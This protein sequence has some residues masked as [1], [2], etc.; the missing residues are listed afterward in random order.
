MTDVE[1]W[2]NRVELKMSMKTLWLDTS[3]MNSTLRRFFD[4]LPWFLKPQI[5]GLAF[6][7]GLFLLVTVIGLGYLTRSD[8]I[9]SP[10]TTAIL[11]IISAPTATLPVP[12]PSLDLTPASEGEPGLESAGEGIVLDGYVQIT[13]TGGT[14]LRFR[15]TPSLA[16]QV[17]F[18]A[19][20]AEIFI[21][22][23]GPMDADGYQ[24]WYLVGPF[25]ETRNGWAVSDFLA[26]TQNPN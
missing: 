22:K 20:E 6:V 13:G 19:S 16:G 7:T 24:W 8:P 10:K 4:Q 18:V 3:K 12:T 26:L 15:L 23:D 21:V 14:G 9:K 2:E 5:I 11:N 25:D 17:K 1:L